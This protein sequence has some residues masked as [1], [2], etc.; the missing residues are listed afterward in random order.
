MKK[1]SIK[2]LFFSELQDIYSAETQIV[3][4]LPDMVKAAES[5]E[6]KDA[7]KKH[8]EETKEQVKRLEKIFKALEIKHPKE[9]CEAMEG[10]ISEGADVIKEYD[11][12]AV[13]DAALISK[14]QRIEHYEIS[15]YGTLRTFAREL[16]LDDIAELLDLSLEE[17]AAADKKLT[18][19][20]EGGLLTAGINQRAH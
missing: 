1:D 17:E 7:F 20:A 4:A 13:R 14:A 19:I 11:K 6:L 2:T 10:L 3:E 16:E 12:S 9:K 5:P 8:L 15:V 18:K